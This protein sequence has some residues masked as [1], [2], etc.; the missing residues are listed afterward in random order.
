[1]YYIFKKLEW[2]HC[3]YLAVY[4][5]GL[6]CYLSRMSSCYLSILL[7]VY[8]TI[9]LSYYR[10]IL[11]YVYLTICLSCYMSIV[12]LSFFLS[13]SLSR[14]SFLLSRLPFFL[15]IC[16]SSYLSVFHAICLDCLFCYLDLSSYLSVFHAIY[17]DCLFCFLDSLY[18][19]IS[20]FLA[21]FNVFFISI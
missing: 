11:P 12:Y 14:L 8:L 7:S 20:V 16:L 2:P 6:S 3:I 21:I 18:F 10:S 5:D 13:F 1:M 4:I 15:F 17:L 19:Y 9:C